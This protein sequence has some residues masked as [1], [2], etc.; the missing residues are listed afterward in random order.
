MYKDR[1]VATARIKISS[2]R[3]VRL[4]SNLRFKPGVATAFLAPDGFL[5]PC[6]SSSPS[7]YHHNGQHGRPS[8]CRFG[9]RRS[10][11]RSVSSYSTHC[12]PVLIR[13]FLF[14]GSCLTYKQRVQILYVDR[15][16]RSFRTISRQRP[17][18][19]MAVGRMVMLMGARRVGRVRAGPG[20]G[21]VRAARRRCPNTLKMR[22]TRERPER[23]SERA[24]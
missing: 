8:K 9:A 2:R 24:R 18:P 20:A 14:L 12:M 10:C 7:S 5:L 11:S 19:A 15:Q 1:G 23:K 16:A 22:T 13:P 3:A 17:T 21:M 6:L 4:G